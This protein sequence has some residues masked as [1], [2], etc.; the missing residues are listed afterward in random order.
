MPKF[1]VPT[2]FSRVVSAPACV[3]LA[4]TLL[5]AA[6][7]AETGRVEKA[8]PME[9]H[10]GYFREE[11]LELAAGQGLDYRFETPHRVDFNL[12]Y[13]PPQGGMEYADRGVISGVHRGQLAAVQEAG[14]YCFM[15][16]N[17]AAAEA[18]YRLE[19]DY[20]RLTD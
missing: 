16:T 17:T 11:C 20:R 2:F 18:A 14:V 8:I 9:A 10:Q 15:W 13:H 6:A 12:H 5:P 7:A 19:L 3:L 1:T 4:C